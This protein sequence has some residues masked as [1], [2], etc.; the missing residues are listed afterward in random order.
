MKR[1][2][3]IFSVNVFLL[4]VPVELALATTNF[5]WNPD[6]FSGTEK[7]IDFESTGVSSSSEVAVVDSV[8][9]ALLER[10]TL[11]NTGHA[12]TLASAPDSTYSR[13]FLPRDGPYFLNMINPQTSTVDLQIQFSGAITRVAA[14]IR[15]GQTLND[16]DSLTFELYIGNFLVSE[17]S[18]DIR[19]QDNFYFYGLESTSVFD[20]WVIRQSPDYRFELENLRY[21]PIP[22]PATIIMFG[23]GLTWL[24]GFLVKRKNKA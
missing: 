15:S 21:A 3:L 11:V 4:F 14:E 16:V 1:N 23:T 18:L 19:G 24:V 2:S 9:F 8:S 10:G 6:R 13:E 22:E 17:T 20:R 5:F 7:L 12:P